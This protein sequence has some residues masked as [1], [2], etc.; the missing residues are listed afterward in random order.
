MCVSAQ[1][2]DVVKQCSA[3]HMGLIPSGNVFLR[4]STL[5]FLVLFV[6]PRI[7][8]NDIFQTIFPLS[9]PESFAGFSWNFA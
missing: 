4:K 2:V 5:R 6:K 9:L 3:Q 7:P 1:G 8:E